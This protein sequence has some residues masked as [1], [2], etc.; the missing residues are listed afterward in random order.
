MNRQVTEA[1]VLKRTNFGEADRIITVITAEGT[2][3]RLMCKG[4]RRPKSKLAGGIELFSITS[5]TYLPGKREMGTLLSGRLKTHWGQ[6]AKEITRT[7]TGYELLKRLDRAT[8]DAA[9][10]DYYQL[11]V[12][13]LGSLNEGV[14]QQLVTLWFDAQLL[15]LAGHQP[16]LQRDQGGQTL[17]VDQTYSFDFEQMAMQPAPRGRY[18]ADQIK[19]LRLVFSLGQPADLAKIAQADQLI[20][21]ASSLITTIRRQYML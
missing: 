2:K 15:K 12:T 9:E 17:R 10:A 4:V 6:L 14:S 19:F 18:R 20:G 13:G 8:E 21:P 5:L 1:I 11:L 16:D 3:L 7:M